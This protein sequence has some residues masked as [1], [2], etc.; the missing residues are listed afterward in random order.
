MEFNDLMCLVRAGFTKED[1]TALVTE[2][3]V[4]IETPKD[5][6]PAPVPEPEPITPV[7]PVVTD[8]SDVVSAINELTK[9][10]QKQA[11][12][13]DAL[14]PVKPESAEDILA[15]IINPKTK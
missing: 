1:I 14:E 7:A 11:V 5:E 8:N 9:L 4:S 13:L 2:K 15:A 10:I 3:P 6:T 12:H